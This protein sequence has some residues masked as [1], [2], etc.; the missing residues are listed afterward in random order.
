MDHLKRELITGI[1]LE[2]AAHKQIHSL[3]EIDRASL[4]QAKHRFSAATP[5]GNA[6]TQSWRAW[7][8]S[9]PSSHLR[10]TS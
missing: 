7:I 8:R 5:N 1:E 2:T 9:R 6:T 3:D 10:P 4:D